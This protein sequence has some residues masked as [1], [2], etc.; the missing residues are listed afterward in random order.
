M[1]DIFW[2]GFYSGVSFMLKLLIIYLCIKLLLVG[3][4]LKLI[5]TQIKNNL[6]QGVKKRGIHKR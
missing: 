5:S 1:M 2:L 6:N 4:A 3:R